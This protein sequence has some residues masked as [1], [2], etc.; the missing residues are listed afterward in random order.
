MPIAALI[1]AYNPDLQLVRLVEA[2]SSS[3][4]AAIV[5]VDDGSRDPSQSIFREIE[6]FPRV[7]LLRHAANLGKGAA[8]KTGL[9]HVYCR[10]AGYRGAVLLD[11]D[12]QHLVQ[13]ALKVAAQLGRFPDS[14]VMGVRTFDREVPLRSRIGNELTG[15]LFRILTGSCLRD[16]QSGLRGVPLQFIPHLL[17]IDSNGYDFE[18]NMLLACKHTGIPGTQQVVSF[19]SRHRLDENLFRA[20]PFHPDLPFV[21]ID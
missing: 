3:S 18:L 19:P 13:D 2:L 4:F 11:A 12:G 17:K 1:P 9:N 10:F 16:T 5:V 21:G 20:F 6:Q 8:L 7:T 15:F 14:L